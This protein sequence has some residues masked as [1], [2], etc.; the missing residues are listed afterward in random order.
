MEKRKLV[1]EIVKT[2]TNERRGEKEEG[3]QDETVMSRID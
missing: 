2:S 3:K 1:L